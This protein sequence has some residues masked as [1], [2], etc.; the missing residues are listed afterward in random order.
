MRNLLLIPRLSLLNRQLSTTKFIL[1]NNPIVRFQETQIQK[2]QTLF[3]PSKKLSLFE[4]HQTM[5]SIKFRSIPY[6]RIATESQKEAEA[7]STK[8]AKKPSKFSLFYKQYGPMF[9]VVHLITV[10]LWIYGFF[11]IS[12]Q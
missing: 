11:L 7:T 1:A 10:V 12:K 6:R 4:P 2:N 9:I 8:E 5:G 3:T